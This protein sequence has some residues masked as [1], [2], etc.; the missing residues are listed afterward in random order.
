LPNITP[1]RT[2]Y[3]LIKPIK[4]DAS[5]TKDELLNLIYEIQSFKSE[6]DNIEV[7]SAAKGAPKIYDSLSSLSNRPGGGVIVFG[8]DEEKVLS[9]WGSITWTI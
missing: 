1:S 4:S 3:Q 5:M 2:N 6:Q 9:R 8:L 7:K